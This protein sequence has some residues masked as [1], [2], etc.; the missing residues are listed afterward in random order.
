MTDTD[1]V[2]DSWLTV[3]NAFTVGLSQNDYDR[4]APYS[5][6]LNGEILPALRDQFPPRRL[7]GMGSDRPRRRAGA[8]LP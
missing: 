1:G 8:R 4:L 6:T 3:P 5:K 7:L 2:T